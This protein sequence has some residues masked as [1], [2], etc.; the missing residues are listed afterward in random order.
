MKL[1]QGEYVALER[2][3]ALYSGCPIIAQLYVHGDSL[4]SYLLGVVIP[5]PVQ[6]AAVASKVWGSVVSEKDQVALDR[7]VKDPKVQEAIL[8]T[9]NKHAK[10]VG[11]QGCVSLLVIYAVCGR[12]VQVLIAAVC[13]F[14]TVKRIHLSNELLTVDNGCLTP[15][16]KLKRYVLSLLTHS[17]LPT[18]PL[19]SLS[20]S[21]S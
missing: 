5:D 16:L 10:S 12:K 21:A 1:S 9:L 18:K 11:L 6:L 17:S 19:T 4:Q 15:T 3:A 20:R 13:R 7:A 8:D 14:E 2:V